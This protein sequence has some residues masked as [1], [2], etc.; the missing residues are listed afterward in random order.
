MCCYRQ[1][2]TLTVANVKVKMSAN[3]LDT[4]PIFKEIDENTIQI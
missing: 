3:V 2:T 4:E 1:I